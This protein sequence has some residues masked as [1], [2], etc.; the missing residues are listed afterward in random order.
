MYIR[1]KD[2]LSRHKK[3]LLNPNIVY[4]TEI[5]I[6]YIKDDK[7]EVY[8]DPNIP[9]VT[10]ESLGLNNVDNTADLS[11]PISTATQT[12]LNNK[13]DTL[14]STTNIK[15]I[16]GNSLLGS[17]NLTIT[18]SGYDGDPTVIVQNSTHRFVS[19]TEISDWNSK[20]PALGSDDNYVTD[21]EKTKLSNLSGTN[22]G[23]QD[24][25]GKLNVPT[26]TPDGTKYLRD[27]NTWQPVSGGSGLAQYQVR[28]II[29]R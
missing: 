9:V 22:T 3:R 2:L 11:K 6:Y 16:N 14:V 13:Q 1:Y 29:R 26:G 7:L 5:G 12:A 27:D 19:D 8:T 28:R 23:D 18:G 20:A 15:S 4:I 24:L 17:G 10:K 25:S 21:A